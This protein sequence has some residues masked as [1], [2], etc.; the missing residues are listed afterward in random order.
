MFKAVSLS[1]NNVPSE[2]I[3]SNNDEIEQNAKLRLTCR[4]SE[5][6]TVC[7]AFCQSNDCRS[8]DFGIK[9]STSARRHDKYPIR[10]S[11]NGSLPTLGV[12]RKHRA[13]MRLLKPS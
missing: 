6:I 8:N 2:I 7:T 3:A 10:T 13:I 9:G 5:S 12:S 4:D 11:T 1:K